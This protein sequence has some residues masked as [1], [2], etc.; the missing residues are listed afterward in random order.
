MSSGESNSDNVG[1]GNNALTAITTGGN[2]I[3]IGREAG[4]LLTTAGQSVLIGRDAGND[5]GRGRR[6]CW[7]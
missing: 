6:R 2:N 5:G 4:D 3:A 1:I 7:V